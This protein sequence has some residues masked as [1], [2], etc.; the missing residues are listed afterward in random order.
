MI[1]F[2]GFG[3]VWADVAVG[4]KAGDWIEYSVSTT[5][6][7]PSPHDVQWARMD[8]IEVSGSNIKVNVTTQ[9][10]NGTYSV[11]LMQLNLERGEIGAWFIIPANLNVGESFYDIKL[12]P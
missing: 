8:I 9:A 3:L 7:P 11:N 12:R 6:A 1:V 5:G 2:F 4:V 10:N